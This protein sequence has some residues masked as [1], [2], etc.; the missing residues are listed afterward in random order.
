MR[1]LCLTLIIISIAFLY[2]MPVTSNAQVQ[3]GSFSG[4]SKSSYQC[5][6]SRGNQVEP[7]DIKDISGYWLCPCNQDPQLPSSQTGKCGPVTASCD[8]TKG[9]RYGDPGC[10]AVRSTL[11]PP[12]LQQLEIWF[13]RIVYV[14]WGFVA[15]FSF[16]FLVALGYRYM[17][18]QG[19]V[20]KT[21]EIRQKIIYYIIGFILVFLA[22][23]IITTIFRLLGVNNNVGCYNVNMPGF[24]FFFT[25]LCTDPLNKVGGEL[26]SNPCAISGG[27]IDGIV[28]AQEEIGRSYT[29]R[30]NQRVSHTG[31]AIS[32]DIVYTCTTRSND[33]SRYV[34]QSSVRQGPVPIN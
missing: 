6:D 12:T 19:D 25:D 26:A 30:G 23:P 5:F 33:S 18:T 32:N 8:T 15:A 31:A 27:S 13:V 21:T 17:I 9:A 34:W 4:S 1:K 24:Q 10:P 16:F 28:C 29:C 14:L 3:D 22:V 11:K 7:T 20:T 2:F